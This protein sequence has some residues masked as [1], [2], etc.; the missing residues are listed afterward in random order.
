MMVKI[1]C[2]PI[3]ELEIDDRLLAILLGRLGNSFDR[4]DILVLIREL[5]EGVI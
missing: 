4:N 2:A 5:Q 1:D 3:G